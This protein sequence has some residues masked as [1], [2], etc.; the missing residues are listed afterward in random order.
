MPSPVTESAIKALLANLGRYL[1][2]LARAG[3]QRKEESRKAL[4]GVIRATRQTQVY[5]RALQVKGKRNFTKEERISDTWT[6]L[7][8]ELGKL[9]VKA[10]AKRCDIA[11]GY[12]S[13]PDKFSDEFLKKA[14][15]R[16]QDLEMEARTLLAKL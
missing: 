10:L 3:L 4:Q 11:G 13:D 2:N 7:S 5:L 1:A 6:K 15:A 9:G 12:W 14:K 16:L 8:F